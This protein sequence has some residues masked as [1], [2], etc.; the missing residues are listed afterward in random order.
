LSKQAHLPTHKP[1][2]QAYWHQLD[3]KRKL[4]GF[5][6][7]R[8]IRLWVRLLQ[9]KPNSSSNF[10]CFHAMQT[11]SLVEQTR[12]LLRFAIQLPSFHRR[13]AQ[14]LSCRVGRFIPDWN[15]ITP[16]PVTAGLILI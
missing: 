14:D 15:L 11:C 12:T 3:D 16:E 10:V 9:V 5:Q 2:A 6:P 1:I 13:P 8:N 4:E 7:Y